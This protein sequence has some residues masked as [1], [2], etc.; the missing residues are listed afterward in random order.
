MGRAE[1]GPPVLSAGQ[2]QS[3]VVLLPLS[4]LFAELLCRPGLSLPLGVIT[5]AFSASPAEPGH[6]LS[7]FP[8]LII[9]PNLGRELLGSQ[10]IISREV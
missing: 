9:R 8:G 6:R 2:G 5:S 4:P 10:I 3:V 7:V 1:S